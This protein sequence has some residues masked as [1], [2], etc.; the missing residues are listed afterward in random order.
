MNIAF[1]VVLGAWFLLSV[2]HQFRRCQRWLSRWDVACLLPTWTFFAPNPGTGEY[3]LLCRDEGCEHN[4]W[5]EVPT[6][7]GR[8]TSHLVW[9]PMRR[10]AKV[11]CDFVQVLV[12]LR[13]L[14]SSDEEESALRLSIPFLLLQQYT[15]TRVPPCP[16]SKSRRF[17][18]VKTHG[19]FSTREPSPVFLSPLCSLSS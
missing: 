17:L 10:Q 18:L 6:L 19:H 12:A 14:S 13:A 4:D 8:S 16:C 5:V 3:H 1:A 2:P 7:Q 11:L 9:N 15:I